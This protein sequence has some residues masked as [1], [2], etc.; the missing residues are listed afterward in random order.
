MICPVCKDT[1]LKMADKHGIEIDYCPKC[2]GIWLDRGE[3]DKIVERAMAIED[4]LKQGKAIPQNQP[5]QQQPPQQQ[6]QQHPNQGYHQPHYDKDY[7]KHKKK[8][9][10]WGEIFDIFD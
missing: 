5:Y 1:E 10:V 3:M 7:Y 4:N 2:R 9:S 6:Y 8:E